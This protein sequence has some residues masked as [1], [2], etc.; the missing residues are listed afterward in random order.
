[1]RIGTLL[2]GIEGVG[3]GAKQAGIE[4]A[5]GVEIDGKAAAIAN[6]NLGDHVRTADILETDPSHFD[7]VDILHASP[8]CVNF[9]NAKANGHES[10][11]DIAV[12]LKVREFIEHHNPRIFTLENVWLYRKSDSWAIIAEKLSSMGY[13]PTVDHVNAADFGVPQTRKRMIVRAVRDG[14]VPMLPQPER[15]VGWY[16]AIEDLAYDLPTTAFT[17]S[18]RLHI[19]NRSIACDY[20]VI[21]GQNRSS[22][23][24]IR[25]MHQPFFT[26][27]ES[28]RCVHRARV[29]NGRVVR[30]TPSCLARFQSFSDWYKNKSMRGI[31]NSVPP[32]LYQKIIKQLV[33]A[34]L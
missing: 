15:W 18:D 23:P 3:V 32:L 24:T 1:M 19:Q 33:E 25:K 26:V 31:G 22:E 30:M 21:N 13:W 29:D 5:W 14:W 8:V 6:R 7:K 28:Q 10:E 12:A 9:S 27:T 11:L 2:S 34:A 17:H 20:F 16:E 4:L